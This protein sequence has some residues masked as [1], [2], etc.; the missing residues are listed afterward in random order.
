[1]GWAEPTITYDRETGTVQVVNS[2]CFEC[3][4]PTRNRDGCSFMRGMAAGLVEGMF[5]RPVQSEE[6]RCIRRGDGVCEFV[7]RRKGAE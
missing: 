2:E 7:L 3:S 6:T 1:M 4:A 5:G